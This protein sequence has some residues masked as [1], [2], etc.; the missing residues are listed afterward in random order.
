MQ[1]RAQQRWESWAKNHTRATLENGSMSSTRHGSCGE[2]TR[3]GACIHE[4]IRLDDLHRTTQHAQRSTHASTTTHI[5]TDNRNLQRIESAISWSVATLPEQR[6]TAMLAACG[7]ACGP[8]ASQQQCEAAASRR[9]C[10]LTKRGG[11]E[12]AVG[13]ALWAA[14]SGRCGCCW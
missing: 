13:G 8:K 4:C 3:S 12:A 1:E 11:Q 14:H 7:A 9:R 5:R 10:G 6:R 2:R